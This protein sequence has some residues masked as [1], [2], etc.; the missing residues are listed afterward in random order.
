MDATY[1]DDVEVTD[2]PIGAA[3]L[4]D[5]VEADDDLAASQ[6]TL[7]DSVEEQDAYTATGTA[8]Y[9]EDLDITD[10]PIGAATL[11]DAVEVRD[12]PVG[13]VILQD[14]HNLNDDL[15][16]TSSTVD[17]EVTLDE[18]QLEARVQVQPTEDTWID[19]DDPNATHGND[20]ILLCRKNVVAVHGARIAYHLYDL[21]KVD[22]FTALA[23]ASHHYNRDSD[24][25]VGLIDLTVEVFVSAAKPFDDST[26]TWNNPPTEGTLLSS[27]TQPTGTGAGS[28]SVTAH[29]AA[30]W[31]SDVEGNW[32]MVKYTVTEA[33]QDPEVSID[34]ADNVALVSLRY[35]IDLEIDDP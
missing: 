3:T 8:T 5:S 29:T 34:A 7:Q 30:E 23:D 2:E 6:A 1:S 15:A 28:T 17:D 26:A 19:E 25:V 32:L 16:A 10:E 13:S 9:D 27:T 4:Q 12:D 11:Q 21:T 31:A 18:T 33:V 24:H 14:A 35:D 22:G 20:A